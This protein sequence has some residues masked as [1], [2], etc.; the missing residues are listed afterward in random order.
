MLRNDLVKCTETLT[1]LDYVI[2]FRK[3]H[4][5]LLEDKNGDFYNSRTIY[6]DTEM[7]NKF[8][9]FGALLINKYRSEKK[10]GLVDKESLLKKDELEMYMKGIS[11]FMSIYSNCIMPYI[12]SFPQSITRYLSPYA[13][14]SQEQINKITT[15]YHCKESESALSE[16]FRNSF[17]DSDSIQLLN[18][19]SGQ[20]FLQQ[21]TYQNLNDFITNLDT[22][23][24][25]HEASNFIQN[26][27][28]TGPNASISAKDNINR[29][30]LILYSVKQSLNIFYKTLYNEIIGKKLNLISED[31]IV[32][33]TIS[34]SILYEIRSF[35][36]TK[37]ALPIIMDTGILTLMNFSYFEEHYHDFGIPLNSQFINKSDLGSI[38]KTQI[39]VLDKNLNPFG[40]YIKSLG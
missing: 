6:V 20:T 24:R 29:F 7:E 13:E 23:I 38:C 32:N 17:S 3:I 39:C 10:L 36:L 21:L 26:V 33:C 37:K 35:T 16:Y 18:N 1:K 5:T 40:N 28:S 9:F 25:N 22:Q 27:L 14:Y 34:K 19:Y 12:H 30:F 31:T 2:K 11:L 4:K 8:N 15:N